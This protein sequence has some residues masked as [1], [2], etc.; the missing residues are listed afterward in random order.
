MK[1]ETIGDKSESV[2][3]INL[4]LRTIAFYGAY[5]IC[6]HTKINPRKNSNC[7]MHFVILGIKKVNNYFDTINGRFSTA[8]FTSDQVSQPVPQQSPSN[9]LRPSLLGPLSGLQRQGPLNPF[10]KALLNPLQRSYEPP[11]STFQTVYE[12][13]L[14]P[15]Y[16]VYGAPFNPL[17][18]P[19]ALP[20][21]AFQTVYKPLLEP[22]KESAAVLPQFD[23]ARFSHSAPS[24]GYNP[25]FE[26]QLGAPIPDQTMANALFFQQ[27]EMTE[28]FFY[29]SMLRNPLNSLTKH[30][31][32][33]VLPM[34]AGLSS[35]ASTDPHA[36]NCSTATRPFRRGAAPVTVE[37]APDQ[38]GRSTKLVRAGWDSLSI[39]DT[40]FT[41]KL[42]VASD[43]T[44]M[45]QPNYRSS[46]PPPPANAARTWDRA[47][48]EEWLESTFDSQSPIDYD[49][50]IAM[51]DDTMPGKTAVFNN[52]HA[53]A[54]K[55]QKL[56]DDYNIDKKNIKQLWRGLFIGSN[57]LDETGANLSVNHI[58][59]N[60]EK[61]V[62]ACLDGENQLDVLVL[63]SITGMQR[64]T[65]I[66]AQNVKDLKEWCSSENRLNVSLFRSV[67]NMQN[68]KGMPKKDD[69]LG[70]KSYF[71]D[72]DDPLKLKTMKKISNMMSGK[73]I[74]QKDPVV[75][76]INACSSYQQDDNLSVLSVI[77]GMQKA[78]GI[79]NKKD[80]D[81]FI[82][83]C[84]I[85]VGDNRPN[86]QLMKAIQF[87]QRGRGIPEKG[88]VDEFKK[89]CKFSEHMW[90]DSDLVSALDWFERGKGIPG[91]DKIDTLK[92]CCPITNDVPDTAFL[93]EL[94]NLFKD[95]RMPD[96]EK[97]EKI[98]NKWK[99]N[100]AVS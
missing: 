78:K 30:S 83:Q 49:F 54:V 32:P 55:M 25:F 61:V 21:N 2:F 18:R 22:I 52:A 40:T 65:P 7:V 10:Q 94:P 36:V 13:P 81:R 95:R 3:V 16:R 74:P 20:L 92:A 62:E 14:N 45:V 64:G 11:P 37:G 86:M 76:V 77:S 84:C 67:T 73:G 75:D 48:I 47:A 39:E 43:I 34:S 70:F 93:R 44:V 79:P 19:H 5:G 90:P 29:P 68:R 28:P 69:V 66:T 57:M 9:P 99:L 41:K 98:Y 51:T 72:I 46:P 17:Q 100:R 53:I 63:A 82:N 12:P 56:I 4:I 50:F 38:F 26:A 87:M 35:M 89:H 24:M 60:S 96:K 88:S 15:F 58:L 85:I 71:D 23:G 27:Q 97:L 80:V 33:D 91:K 6:S 1:H 8:L 42:E 31:V 59:E